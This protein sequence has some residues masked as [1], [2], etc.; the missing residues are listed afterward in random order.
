[1]P[2]VPARSPQSG[3]LANTAPARVYFLRAG[4]VHSRL[5]ASVDLGARANAC[6]AA[7]GAKDAPGADEVAQMLLRDPRAFWALA[8]G[9]EPFL[10]ELRALAV[11]R[12]GVSRGVWAQM[13][14]APILLGARRKRR[15]DSEKA[16]KARE[17]AGEDEEDVEFEY[18][19]VRA[20]Q[21]V[22]ADDTNEWQL[23]GDEVFSCPQEDLLEGAPSFRG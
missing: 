10:A 14:R 17:A 2:I 7:L 8:D 9:R 5:F 12:A 4:G 20:D 1:M 23:F 15:E 6:L 22:I 13:K 3:A 16:E 11:G 19:L 18:E 21:V